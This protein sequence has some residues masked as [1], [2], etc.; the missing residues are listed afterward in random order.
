MRRE[1]GDAGIEDVCPAVASLP[2]QFPEHLTQALAD[3]GDWLAEQTAGSLPETQPAVRRCLVGGS[4][5]ARLGHSGDGDTAPSD[6]DLLVELSWPAATADQRDVFGQVYEDDLWG[7]PPNALDGTHVVDP[8]VTAYENDPTA[9]DRWRAGWARAD[10][11]TTVYDV[12]SGEYVTT[13]APVR[14]RGER[15]N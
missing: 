13:D 15:S 12:L 4:F 5:G 9:F 7:H 11:I 1:R 6:I 2:D 3:H 10:D 8:A 14:V